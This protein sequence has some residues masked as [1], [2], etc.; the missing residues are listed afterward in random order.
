MAEIDYQKEKSWKIEEAL[1]IPAIA[2]KNRHGDYEL[3]IPPMSVRY[4]T[5]WE[6]YSSLAHGESYGFSY[7]YTH[8]VAKLSVTENGLAELRQNHS[9]KL[10]VMDQKDY[11]QS[12]HDFAHHWRFEL[13]T[14]GEARS[15]TDELSRYLKIDGAIHHLL[16]TIK[17]SGKNHDVWIGHRKA[18]SKGQAHTRISAWPGIS[19]GKL[20]ALLDSGDIMKVGVLEN[21]DY[22]Y[23]E[24]D[25]TGDTKPPQKTSVPHKPMPEIVDFAHKWGFEILKQ[26]EAVKAEW[27]EL[28][29]IINPA[30]IAKQIRL[31]MGK[32]EESGKY[33][34]WLG[35]R[36]FRHEM[37]KE[38]AFTK[39]AGWEKLS[40]AAFF[41]LMQ[42]GDI[43]TKLLQTAASSIKK[44]EEER[45]SEVVQWAARYEKQKDKVSLNIFEMNLSR[46]AD[47]FLLFFPERLAD[48]FRFNA[49][50]PARQRIAISEELEILISLQTISGK[51]VLAGLEPAPKRYAKSFNKPLAELDEKQLHKLLR[52]FV[53]SS[54]DISQL[55]LLGVMFNEQGTV[56]T[57]L[58]KLIYLPYIH[59]QKGIYCLHKNCFEQHGDAEITEY[60]FPNIQAAIPA[61]KDLSHHVTFEIQPLLDHIS[62]LEKYGL[63]KS[64]DLIRAYGMIDFP[65]D[66]GK[67]VQVAVNL[68]MV[69]DCLQTMLLLGY[70]EAVWGAQ[71]A[72]KATMLTPKIASTAKK[73]LVQAGNMKQLMMLVMPLLSGGAMGDSHVDSLSAANHFYHIRRGFSYNLKANAHR[74]LGLSPNTFNPYIEAIQS[75]ELAMSFATDKSLYQETI[76]TLKLAMSL[77]S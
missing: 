68:D 64:A 12:L 4:E 72:G 3:L 27:D 33:E 35:W 52:P 76:E 50:L 74:L 51:D 70:K 5:F 23:H 32:G 16:I 25:V 45:W 28:T 10:N 54:K 34:I 67:P 15:D 61:G 77:S 19:E 66:N 47:E 17:E 49:L 69:K 73:N 37:E 48:Y 30:G 1:P 22:D 75:M 43:M 24:S 2:K 57:D 13:L 56:A 39:I 40:Q 53:I 9:D 65:G 36:V 29:R 60:K 58:H 62:L 26:A 11:P 38:I 42:S 8:G 20:Q 46:W 71:S 41:D 59:K 7:D 14:A 31:W 18:G 63:Y 55:A 21:A 44:Y 6:I